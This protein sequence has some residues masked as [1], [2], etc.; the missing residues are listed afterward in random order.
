MGQGVTTCNPNKDYE[1]ANDNCKD[2][3]Y[4]TFFQWK[5]SYL[6]VFSLKIQITT[7]KFLKTLN[8]GY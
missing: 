7:Y 3:T 4:Q 8:Y 6:K 2:V 5:H 1:S